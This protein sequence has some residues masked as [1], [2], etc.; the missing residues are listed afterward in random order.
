MPLQGMNT[1]QHWDCLGVALRSLISFWFSE[2]LLMG[3]PGI[4]STREQGCRSL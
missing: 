4:G 2:P 1:H 3:N